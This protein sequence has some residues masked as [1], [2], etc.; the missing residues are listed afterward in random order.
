MV[1][2]VILNLG[3]I[4]LITLVI[5]LVLRFFNQPVLMAYILAAFI[6]SPFVANLM[7][8]E[9]V[10]EPFAEIGISLLL[11]LVGL[12]LNPSELKGVGKVSL[13][14][15]I[16]QMIFTAVLGYFLGIF[17]GFSS[18]SS[19]YIGLA[20]AFSST[21][22]VMKVLSDKDETNTLHG[23]ISIGFLIVQDL[24][25][26]LIIFGVLIVGKVALGTELV[27][28]TLEIFG[29]GILL[30]V[31]FL[32]FS[33]FILPRFTSFLAKSQEMLLLFSLS[34]ALV[35]SAIF[36][37]LGLTLEIGA[38]LAGVCLSFSQY[39]YE[40]SSKLTPLKDFFLIVFFIS[41]APLLIIS[42]LVENIVPIIILSL[43]VLVGNPLIVLFTMGSLGYTKRNSF[44]AG[45]TVAQI[46]EFSFILV[47]LGV[48]LGHISSE[49]LS[50]VVAVGVITIAGSYY[51]MVYA[52]PLYNRLSR[53][54]GI[55]ER[56][57][58]KGSIEDIKCIDNYDVVLF[59]YNRMGYDLLE[60]FVKKGHRTLVVDYNPDTVKYLRKKG[61]EC[62]YGDAED[63]ELLN[64]IHFRHVKMCVST[65]LDDNT[66]KMLLE[67]IKDIRSDILFIGVSNNL[68]GATKLY[69]MG[70][71]Y[72]ITPPF[73]GGVH[74]S[75]LIDKNGFNSKSYKEEAKKDRAYLRK[76]LKEHHI[77]LYKKG[78]G[79]RVK[80]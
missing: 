15:G 37:S 39:R 77:L 57:K 47:A 52:N 74:T 9:K 54:L 38:L 3:I 50:I 66:N 8:H 68:E 29:V 51:M 7:A 67:R 69:D 40:I 59:G 64:E 23:K 33:Y 20:L 48:S 75:E 53:F 5:A 28:A 80:G 4:L 32:L 11:F 1:D 79:K 62:I 25:H 42:S 34:W 21:I 45:L 14:T 60:S 70:S 44:L 19:L 31:G 58:R 10:F 22:I 18:I 17:L 72:V 43:L 55:F 49:I 2:S 16:G 30:I 63:I 56:K 71:D 35:I 12:N 36:Y 73:L 65:I 76:R 13:I 26:V 41:L 78:S 46:S 61:V 24:V 6:V 27:N